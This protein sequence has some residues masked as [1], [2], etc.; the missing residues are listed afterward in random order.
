V[1]FTT[2]GQQI[3]LYD[4]IVDR[5]N[6]QNLPELAGVPKVFLVQACR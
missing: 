1:I 5:F 6:G 3:D 2:D 4:D